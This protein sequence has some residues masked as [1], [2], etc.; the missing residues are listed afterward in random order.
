MTRRMRARPLLLVASLILLVLAACSGG[1]G[2]NGSGG[3]GGG[4]S[5]GG[6]G[7]GTEVSLTGFA[8]S[9]ASITVSAGDTVTFVNGDSAPHTVTEGQNGE[10]ADDPIVDEEVA[11]NSEIQVTFD[12]PG[13]YQITCLFH[14]NMNMTVTVEG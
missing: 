4:S 13:T 6:G 10:A 2:G 12:E 5:E 3:G 1:D 7:S 14:S 9:P 8:F 11:G